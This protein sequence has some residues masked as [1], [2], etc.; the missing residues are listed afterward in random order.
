MPHVFE[1]TISR[2]RGRSR[3]LRIYAWMM[4]F[5]IIATV[6][7]S[8]MFYVYVA[9]KLGTI[10]VNLLDKPSVSDK[11]S[12]REESVELAKL[13]L[14]LEIKK[15]EQATQSE[16]N[17][18]IY[19]LI[20]AIVLRLASVLISL[21]LVQ[22]LLVFTRYHFRLSD[23]LDA[24]ANSLAVCNDTN[25]LSTMVSLLSPTNIDFGKNPETPV[26]KILDV[27]KEALSKVKA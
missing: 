8:I 12:R 24:C 13:R 17:S 15:T 16:H 11:I 2:L 20:S 1:E 14:E 4:V 6:F 22:I 7:S 5:L 25:D 3:T 21:Y 27:I 10:S 19:I 26:E 9:N 18:N 23:H